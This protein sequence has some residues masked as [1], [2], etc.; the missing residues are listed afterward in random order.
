MTSTSISM[1]CLNT[2]ENPKLSLHRLLLANLSIDVRLN[3]WCA[4]IQHRSLLKFNENSLKLSPRTNDTGKHALRS[5]YVGRNFVGQKWWIFS[6]M[7]TISPDD[8]FCP[9]TISPD[10][11][12]QL[13]KHFGNHHFLH[14]SYLCADISW[15]FLKR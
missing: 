10:E 9:T 2:I 6:L 5:E 7:T 8:W 3:F 4:N 12:F 13:T 15:H 14:K 11:K 1:C